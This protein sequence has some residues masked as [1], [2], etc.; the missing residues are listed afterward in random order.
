MTLTEKFLQCCECFSHKTAIVDEGGAISY[1]ELLKTTAGLAR[2]FQGLDQPR[3]GMCLPN[4][5]EFVASYFSLLF[6]GITPVIVNPLLSQAQIAHIVKDAS[7]DTIITVS[8]FKDLLG[9]LVKECIY[10]D[11]APL[12]STD[13]SL[14]LPT[15]CMGKEEDVAVIFYTSGTS[16]NPKGVLLTHRNILSNLEGY[17]H[18]FDFNDR[19][20]ILGVLPLFH[21]FAFTATLAM[22][23]LFGASVVYISR[24]S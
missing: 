16:A 17:L 22:P 4:C 9:E 24:F 7:I 5:K 6:N 8:F 2:T 3:V 10:L 14:V 13:P 21:A 12:P 18:D 11:Q 19:D 23:L 1:G 20:V 15:L